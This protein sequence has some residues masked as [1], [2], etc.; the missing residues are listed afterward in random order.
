ML[1]AQGAAAVLKCLPVRRIGNLVRAA[2][3]ACHMPMEWH[4]SSIASLY[5]Q[6]GKGE[7]KFTERRLK[8][9]ATEPQMLYNLSSE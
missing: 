6:K 1:L 3:I 9:T 2:I 5:K 8:L 7:A 4:G